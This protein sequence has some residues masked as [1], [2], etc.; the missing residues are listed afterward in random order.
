MSLVY[1][2]PITLLFLPILLCCSEAITVEE[3]DMG[4]IVDIKLIDT[5][6]DHSKVEDNEDIITVEV[7]FDDISDIQDIKEDVNQQDIIN[8]NEDPENCGSIGFACREHIKPDN[9]NGDPTLVL[10]IAGKCVIEQCISGRADCNNNYEDGCEVYTG[11]DSNNCG[12]CGN[13][14]QF[15]NSVSDCQFSTCSLVN[16][17]NPYANCDNNISNGCETD[18]SKDINNC[19]RCHKIC[20]FPNAYSECVNSECKFIGCKSGY[21][22]LNGDIKD[23]C[24]YQCSITNN[25]VEVCDGIDNNCNGFID[26]TCSCINGSKMPCGFNI[27]RCKEGYY[28]CVD[29]V[30]DTVCKG[31]VGPTY[32]ECNNLDDDCNG[33]TDDNLFRECEGSD[34]YL[35]D[36]PCGK[37]YEFCEKGVWKRYNPPQ[38]S[39]EIC[40][41]I[42]DN[43]NGLI[44]EGSAKC[45]SDMVAVG[46]CLCIDRFE[47]SRP[48]AT[49]KSAGV[50]N[51]YATSRAGVLPWTEVDWF[52]ADKACK[53]AGKRLCT[54]EEWRKACQGEG[55]Y[56]YPYGNTFDPSACNGSDDPNPGN[57]F[58]TGTYAKCK[59]TYGSFDMS[60]NIE[61]W[62]ATDYPDGKKGVRGGSY[63]NGNELYT[64]CSYEAPPVKADF[65]S[66]TIGFRCCKTP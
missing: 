33:L 57:V 43:C 31:S 37:G 47:A 35:C 23:G 45:P 63:L 18:T 39:E 42:D 41:G 54:A 19:G 30:W 34:A 13:K 32:E 38:P 8:L 29:G 40:N 66:R 14:C 46:L 36:S 26:E 28:E 3:Y 52:T 64:K 58:P 5:L 65:K 44:D 56:V 1:K 10:C 61:E 7:E 9:P 20:A 16:C 11:S 53:A 55:N 62:N 51:S 2:L 59:S 25:G 48:D 24:E 17:I 50:N 15:P 21:V 27:G 4:Y 49:D 12:Y 60:G 22:N 6:K